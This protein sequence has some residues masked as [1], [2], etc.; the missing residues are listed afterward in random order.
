MLIFPLSKNY[1]QQAQTRSTT[2]Q[3][4]SRMELLKLMNEIQG[5]YTTKDLDVDCYPINNHISKIFAR[6]KATSRLDLETKHNNAFVDFLLVLSE[7]VTRMAQNKH[8]MKGFVATGMADTKFN[9]YSHFNKMLALVV[10]IHLEVSIKRA[11][12]LL[13][14]YFMRLVE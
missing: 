7:M 9:K 1:V 2:E 3:L 14:R 6:L 12:H 4:C 11:T 13:L 5:E 10:V 8:I